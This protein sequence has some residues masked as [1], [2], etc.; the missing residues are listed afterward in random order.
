MDYT[1][2]LGAV[3]RNMGPLMDGLWVTLQLTLAANAIG[4]IA[5]FALALL[6]TSKLAVLRLPAMLFVEFFRCTPAIVQIVWFFYCVPM[7]F[8]VFW[9]PVFMGIVALGLNL[10]AFNAE[11]YRASIQAVPREHLDAGIALGLSPTQRVL[12]IVLPQALRN[13]VP[14]L[15]TNGI[16]IFQQSAL[17]AIVGVADLMYQGKTLATATYRPIE[18]FT[19]V[20]LIYLAIS[21]PVGQFVNW[22]ERRQ[23]YS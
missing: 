22:L 16:G 5:G 11:A 10:T 15:L 12:N 23:S 6:T 9:G 21:Y 19:V 13:S 8:N 14:V 17:V 3:T 4:V 18:T 2:D 1:L 7:I 20:A